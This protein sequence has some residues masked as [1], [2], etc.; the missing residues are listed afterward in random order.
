MARTVGARL[1]VADVADVAEGAAE[2]LLLS[3]AIATGAVGFAAGDAVGATAC[4]GTIAAAIAVRPRA[5]A[6]AML[7]RKLLSDTM[8]GDLT[9]GASAEARRLR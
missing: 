7:D 2:T 3:A 9:S 1:V 4:C 5:Q 8:L 6:V